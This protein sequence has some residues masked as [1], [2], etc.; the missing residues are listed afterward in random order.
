MNL[1]CEGAYFQAYLF[2]WTV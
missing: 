2:R 1:I